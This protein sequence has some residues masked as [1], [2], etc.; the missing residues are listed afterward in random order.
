L[1]LVRSNLQFLI[2]SIPAMAFSTLMFS[3][4]VGAQANKP[5]FEYY[6]AGE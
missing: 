5:S 1:I 4:V 6:F 3:V 2:P